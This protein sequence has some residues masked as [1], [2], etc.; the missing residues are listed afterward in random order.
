M[1]R[2]RRRRADAA[3]ALTVGEGIPELGTSGIKVSGG[4]IID[5]ASK[6][7]RNQR[8]RYRLYRE[9]R[10]NCAPITA[11]RLAIEQLLRQVPIYVSAASDNPAD[12]E[13]ADFVDECLHDMSKSWGD[14]LAQALTML[15]YGFAPLEIVYKRRGG[16]VEDPTRRSRYSDGKIGW[17]KVALRPQ[18]TVDRWEFGDDGGF[19]GIYQ[20]DPSTGTETFIPI[21]K[22]LL[23]RT[24]DNGSPE[25]RSLYRG[26]IYPWTFA[27]RMMEIEAIGHERNM[28]GV[29]IMYIP[30]ECMSANATATQR[31]IFDACKEIVTAVH[32]HEN[33]GFVM[34]QSFDANGNERYKFELVSAAGGAGEKAG[35]GEVIQRYEQRMLMCLLADFILLGHEQVGSFSLSSDKTDLFAV[36]VGAWLDSILEVWNRFAVPRLFAIN[37]MRQEPPTIKHGDIEKQDLASLGTFLLNVANAGIMLDDADGS[38]QRHLREVG[39]LPVPVTDDE[40]ATPTVGKRRRG[41]YGDGAMLRSLVAEVQKLNAEI[42]TGYKSELARAAKAER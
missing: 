28:A 26:C 22:L 21:D 5:E 35:L 41:R 32:N 13:A 2:R 29:P 16:D 3:K 11:A 10:D 7:V 17:R 30:E 8:D 25:G 24:T 12:V 1:P 31:A 42:K 39:G 27:K 40:M 15:D 33:G 36:A 19:D 6:L 18:Q 4:R 14:T 9:I 38:L 20:R 34:P 37:G 23:F